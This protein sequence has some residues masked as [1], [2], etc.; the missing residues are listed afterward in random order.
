[1]AATT[2]LNAALATLKRVLADLTA[3][4]RRFA[5]IGGLAVGA[6]AE[7]RTTRDV[8]LAVAV[9]DDRDAE[10][11]VRALLSRGYQIVTTLEQDAAGRLATGPPPSASGTGES[12]DRRPALCVLRH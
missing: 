11:L 4:K 9:A 10:S 12:R 5:L 1:M 7:P 6:R 8:D 3:E 2:P